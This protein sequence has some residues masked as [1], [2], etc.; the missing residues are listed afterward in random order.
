MTKSYC[1]LCYE[2]FTHLI[3]QAQLYLLPQCLIFLEN[4]AYVWQNKK[5]ELMLMRRTKAYSSSSSQTV[6]L[7]P[8]FSLQFILGFCAAAEDC[9]N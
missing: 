8:A 9:T 1:N 4:V 2:R 6:S 3:C 7:S 5:F